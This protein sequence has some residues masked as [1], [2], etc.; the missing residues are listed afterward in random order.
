M[1]PIKVEVL[2]CFMI[3]ILTGIEDTSNG[4]I[5]SYA[6]MT[7][8]L[9]AS[10]ATYCG[11]TYWIFSTLFRYLTAVFTIK[12]SVKLKN[13]TILMI[14]IG[15]AC[16]FLHFFKY[17]LLVVIVGSVGFGICC[18]SV[19]PLI[20]ASTMEFDIKYNPFQ[21]SNLMVA[22]FFAPMLLTSPTGKLMNLNIN[23]LFFS[24]IAMSL[25]ML[26]GYFVFMHILAKVQDE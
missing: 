16:Y 5:P 15:C 24:L 7:G 2:A 4:W 10:Q 21:V 19:F 14:F 3:F 9:N 26:I 11:T 13:Y 25:L 8:A 23:V 1:A 22:P 12:N 17:Y 6:V 18:S 20:V